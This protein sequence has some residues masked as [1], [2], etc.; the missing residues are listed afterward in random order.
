MDG[1]TAVVIG[2]GGTIGRA[3]AL[4]LARSG[5]EIIAVDASPAANDATC[6]EVSAHGGR[7]TGMVADIA[8]PA[9]IGDVAAVCRQQWASVGVLV[10]CHFHT[11]WQSIE[12]SAVE[13][14]EE[15]IRINL[16]GPVVCTKAFLPLLKRAGRAA[17]VHL[18]SVDGNLGNPRVPSYSAAKG[19]LVPL[20]HVMAHEFAQYGIRVNC[21][22]R[23]AV[24]ETGPPPGRREHV[25][26]VTPL[27][28]VAQ[29]DEIAA[30]VAFVASE[31]ASYVTGSII[32]VD[33]GRTAIT[34]GTG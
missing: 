31:D 25:V 32:V 10:N 21:V 7:A 20:T 34:P 30:A 28:R 29:P 18:G 15:A 2:A 26:A 4:R 12:E 33:G 27:G 5:A 14:W 8:N 17:I 11:V 23:A 6:Q 16:L 13:S 9:E 3:C 24:E 19:G 22:A 1:L